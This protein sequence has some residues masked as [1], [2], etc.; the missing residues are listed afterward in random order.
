MR[1]IDDALEKAVIAGF[2][3]QSEAD[4]LKMLFDR[5]RCVDIPDGALEAVRTLC[6]RNERKE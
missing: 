1:H 2:L 3:T 5:T 6:Q 4:C